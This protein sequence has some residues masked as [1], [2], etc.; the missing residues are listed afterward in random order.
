M[1]ISAPH[2]RSQNI[3]LLMCCVVYACA[4]EGAVQD[5]RRGE[6]REGEEEGEGG[7]QTEGEREG[8]R[9]FSAK[10]RDSIAMPVPHR[11]GV[12]GGGPEYTRHPAGRTDG[13]TANLSRGSP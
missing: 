11:G 2:C 6:G 4:C 9:G 5:G 7:G 8:A 10:F 13:W 1:E 12:G 3:W